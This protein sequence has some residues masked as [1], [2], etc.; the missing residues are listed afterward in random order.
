MNRL[1]LKCKDCDKKF[2]GAAIND[3]DA[4]IGREIYEECFH[5]D[6]HGPHKV[7]DAVI[8]DYKMAQQHKG[9]THVQ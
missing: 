9:S 8:V 7:S 4:V 5:C 3:E 6:H 1:T 2:N